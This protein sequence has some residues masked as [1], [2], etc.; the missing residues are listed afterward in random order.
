MNWLVCAECEHQ[1]KC[2]FVVTSVVT[3]CASTP[4]WGKPSERPVP[5][6]RDKDQQSNRPPYIIDTHHRANPQ[7]RP[8]EG[9]RPF[10]AITVRPWHLRDSISETTHQS[11]LLHM[12]DEGR[13]VSEVTTTHPVLT[14]IRAYI[15]LKPRA[16]QIDRALTCSWAPGTTSSGARAASHGCRW[17][18]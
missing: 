18:G 6:S 17:Y 13:E 3:S 9:Q 16:R 2:T 1:L 11:N 10:P 5:S 8:K 4:P 14:Y 12:R 15:D 7:S